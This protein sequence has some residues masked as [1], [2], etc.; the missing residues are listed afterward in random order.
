MFWIIGPALFQTL[1][2]QFLLE[3][4]LYAFRVR[5]KSKFKGKSITERRGAG[6]KRREIKR[7][8]LRPKQGNLGLSCPLLIQSDSVGDG[9]H[10]VETDAGVFLGKGPR[11]FS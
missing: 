2:A 10:P 3:L 9:G 5:Y 11:Q 4:F 7:R 6:K 1:S 8:G